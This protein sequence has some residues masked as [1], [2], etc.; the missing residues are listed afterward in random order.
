MQPYASQEHISLIYN[1]PFVPPVSTAL[2]NELVLIA[3]R[4]AVGQSQQRQA[5]PL[6]TSVPF[7]KRQPQPRQ[8]VSFVPRALP[9][10]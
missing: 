10:R 6:V 7:V 5:P 9:S 4:A 3:S 2:C 1:A 8:F